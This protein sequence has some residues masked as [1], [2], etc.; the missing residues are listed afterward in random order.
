[1]FRRALQLTP[2]GTSYRPMVEQA[3][4]A[5]EAPPVQRPLGPFQQRMR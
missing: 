3:V 4:A 5:L 2:E 1:L